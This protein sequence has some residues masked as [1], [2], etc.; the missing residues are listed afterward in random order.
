LDNEEFNHVDDLDLTKDVWITLRM[1]PEGL[2]PM[3]MAKIE[4]LEG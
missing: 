3:R 1:A 2:K 4:M